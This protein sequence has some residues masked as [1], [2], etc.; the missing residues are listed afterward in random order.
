VLSDYKMP[1]FNGMEALAIVRASGLDLPFILISGA[2][3]E[4]TAVEAMRGGANDYFVKHRLARLGPA[5]TR[6]LREATGRRA[7]RA[8]EARVRQLFHAVEQAPIA[9]VITTA[10]GEIEYVNP[11]FTEVTG[12]SLDEVRGRN[13]RILKSGRQSESVYRD[14]WRT[15]LAG[16][17]WRGELCNR[18]KDGRLFWELASISPIR[19]DQGH[20][21]HFLAAK[22][23]I[24]A[25]IVAARQTEQQAAL[26]DIAS[27]AIY[28]RELDGTIRFWSR[29]AE[30]LYGWTR[31]EAQGRRLTEL[32]LQE[33]DPEGEREQT[34]MNEGSWTG[35][36]RQVTKDQRSI[37]AF[38]R[39]TLVKDEEG[40][41]ASVFATSTDITAKKKL[42][43]QFLR[44]QRLESIG[45]L[46]AGIAHD[47]NNVLAPILMGVQLLRGPA[48]KE[49]DRRLLTVMGQ[50]AERG[51]GL[52][53]QILGFVHGMGGEP[54]IV[55]VKHL[56][57]DIA[58]VVKET[59]PKSIILEESIPKDLW[60]I[61]ANPTQ[62]H[63]V[64]LNLCINARDAMPQGGT[65]RLRAE[66]TLL[67][68]AAARQ[69]EG[70]RP[71]PWIVL[72][73]HDTGVASRPK[74]WARSG[75]LFLPPRRRTRAPGWSSR[76]C[77]GS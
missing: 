10:N 61:M 16:G 24:T 49:S 68:E 40:R 63:Q 27:D 5:I 72:Q 20:I 8:A 30:R 65:L 32:N 71:G 54:R 34:L 25:Q 44:V 69:M 66:N 76:P 13:P 45:M 1:N 37:V 3:G 67:D 55:Q 77:S 29:G 70:A 59:F 42:E 53:R 56:L 62:I 41:P 43:E 46:A 64:L 22:Q 11:K 31:E 74:T 19:D 60:P 39:L 2:V 47:L 36:R 9:F 28:V 17:E 33:M 35:E 58:G 52:V 38:T 6:E 50:S 26:L 23:D 7:H 48:V 75:I 21:T 57:R 18:T 12:Y 4:E 73:A 15:I 51:A 14:L